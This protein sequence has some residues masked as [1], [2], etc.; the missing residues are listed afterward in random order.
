MDEISEREYYSQL[1]DT[2]MND[3]ALNWDYL[4]RMIRDLGELATY[5]SP[6]GLQKSLHYLVKITCR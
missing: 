6:D 2:K 3:Y 1:I 4:N 5:F